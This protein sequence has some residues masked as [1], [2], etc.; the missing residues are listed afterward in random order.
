MTPRKLA[1]AIREHRTQHRI[2]AALKVNPYYVNRYLKYGKEPSNAIIRAKMGFPKLRT[3]H[4]GR[5]GF[6]E[7]PEHV[8]WWRKLDKETRGD[9]IKDAY[10][11]HRAKARHY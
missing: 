5:S 4:N 1:R 8:K 10:E 11:I 9:W 6:A 2:A 7:L 3:R